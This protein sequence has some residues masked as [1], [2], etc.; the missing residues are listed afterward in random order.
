MATV[1]SANISLLSLPSPTLIVDSEPLLDLTLEL[2]DDVSIGQSVMSTPSQYNETAAP[3][4]FATMEE[5]STSEM[6]KGEILRVELVR[7]LWKNSC[8][9]QNFSA[10]LVEVLF[11]KDT[12]KRSNVVGKNVLIKGTKLDS[13]IFPYLTAFIMSVNITKRVTLTL[14]SHPICEL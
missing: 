8:S 14:I 1:V 9:C 4:S 7:K 12:R 11:D 13:N 2:S 10:R 3:P 5:V 6:E